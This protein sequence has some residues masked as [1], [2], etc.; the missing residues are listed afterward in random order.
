MTPMDHYTP[1]RLILE[2]HRTMARVAE[3]RS[4]LV[5]ESEHTPFRGWMAGRLRELADRLDGRPAAH[6][7]VVQ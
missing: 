3:E 5:P 4:R 2:A 6:L 1:E 7:R